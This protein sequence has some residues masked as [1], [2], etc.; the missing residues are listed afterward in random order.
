[1]LDPNWSFSYIYTWNKV[2]EPLTKI[3]YTDLYATYKNLQDSDTSRIRAYK[4]WIFG[5]REL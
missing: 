3:T 1:M 4:F 2:R 5:V